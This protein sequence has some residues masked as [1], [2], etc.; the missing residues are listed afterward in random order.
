M[1][2]R[3]LSLWF[4]TFAS[5]LALRRLGA[6]AR[7]MPFA[8]IA[9]AGRGEDLACVN[10]PAAARG[11]R[12]GQALSE[13][14]ALVPD[15]VTRA[16]DGPAQAQALA[17]LRR[18]AL[19]YAPWVGPDGVDGLVLDITG[20]AHLAGGER[21]LAEDACARL[22]RMGL[23]V[24]V[25][26]APTRGAAWALA[27]FGELSARVARAGAVDP[28]SPGPDAMPGP[29]GPPRAEPGRPQARPDAPPVERGASHRGGQARRGCASERASDPLPPGAG[30]GTAGAGGERARDRAAVC[31][32]AAQTQAAPRA[33]VPFAPSFAPIL[34]ADDPAPALAPLPV[35][36]L[37]LPP[38]TCAAL[39]RVGLRRVGDLAIT[40]RAPLARRFGA[41]VLHRLDQAMGHVADPV[42]PDPAPRIQAIRLTL[43][44]PIGL[45]ADVEAALA[46][47]LDRLCDRLAETQEGARQVR[48]EISR[49]DGTRAQADI[50]LARAMRDPQAMAR[51]FDRALDALDAGF[52]IDALRLSAVQ[53]EPL[54]PAQLTTQSRTGAD[55]LADLLTR[56]GTRLGLEAITRLLPADSHI[57]ERAFQTASAVWADAAPPG[58]WPLGPARPLILFPPEP[59]AGVTGPVP[60][61]R[62]HWRRRALTTTQAEGPERVTPEWWFDDPAWRTGLRDYWRVITAE[63]PR[64]WL[65]HTPQSPGWAVQGEFA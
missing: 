25:G 12:A 65:Y 13:A 47:L 35:A 8:V 39:A 50:Q 62:F 38:E 52:G 60:P 31:A 40:P 36:A 44:D 59:L 57:P 6:G 27:R 22:A 18:W 5:D 53:V 23:A 61:Q 56:L 7:D 43:P 24:R 42:T 51:L 14:R 26:L 48:L 33:G 16:H 45:R 46:R 3:I 4:P 21:A 10:I 32:G 37:R 17:A 58:A 49:A 29:T 19:R 2:R 54:H 11:L 20:A 41:E 15:L 63:G 55:A 30:H 9:R 28:A 1:S 34:A 64:L